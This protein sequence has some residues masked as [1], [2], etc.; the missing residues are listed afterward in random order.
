MYSNIKRRHDRLIGHTL[1]NE[2]LLGTISEC[3]IEERKRKRRQRLK[4]V[5]KVH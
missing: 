2:G 1:N 4:Y 3:T 5:K